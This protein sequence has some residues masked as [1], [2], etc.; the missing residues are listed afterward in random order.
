MA[1]LVKEGATVED[2]SLPNVAADC[3]AVER[4]CACRSAR[5]PPGAR[6]ISRRARRNMARMCAAG[7]S[8]AA[9]SAR[10]SIGWHAR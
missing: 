9:R 7:W 2:V 1:D 10:W 4:H 3:R 5:I 6:D 8:R